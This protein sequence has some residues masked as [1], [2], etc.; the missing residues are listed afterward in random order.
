MQSAQD[1]DWGRNEIEP[2]KAHIDRVCK[3]TDRYS[4]LLGNHDFWVERK[5]LEWG[6]AGQ[7]LWSEVNPRK[8]LYGDYDSSAVTV[9]SYINDHDITACLR[10]APNL[11]AIHGWT[12]CKSAAEKHLEKAVKAGCSVIYGHTHRIQTATTRHPFTDE[13]FQAWSPGCLRSLRP[14]Y[15]QSNGP[16]DWAHGFS[17]IYQSSRNPRDWTAYTPII[18]GGVVV[19]PD[20]AEVRV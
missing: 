9:V 11:L 10:L 17:M 2:A 14:A 5:C 8:V 19:M 3:Y 16:T 20:G 13:V 15:S 7:A 6:V 1:Y 18:N 12:A 4:A